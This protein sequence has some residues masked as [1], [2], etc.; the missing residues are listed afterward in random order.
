[1]EINFATL[2]YLFLRLAPFVLVCFFSLL[3]IFNFD[4]KGVVY[5]VGVIITMTVSIVSGN[6]ITAIFPNIIQKPD[7][8][9]CDIINLSS[10]IPSL[11]IGQSIIGFTS[12]YLISTLYFNDSNYKNNAILNNWPTIAFFSILVICD[13]YWNNFKNKCYGKLHSL[14]TYGSSIAVGILWSSIIFDTKTPSLQFFPK[15]KNNELC[16]RASE[17]TFKCRVYRGGKLVGSV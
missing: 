1:M 4:L 8:L 13:I 12:A 3:S 11:P 15:Y 5:L 10:S 7:G 2:F 16:K 17:K 14:I 6:L 9:L